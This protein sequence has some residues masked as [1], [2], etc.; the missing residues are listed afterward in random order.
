M[1][2]ATERGAALRRQ[3]GLQGQVD[4]EAVA[5]SLGLI[6]RR[7]PFAVLGE[8]RLGDYI[9]VANRL[10]P[11]WQRWVIAHA[12]GHRLLHP[13]NRLHVLLHPGNH[14][15]VHGLANLTDSFEHEADDFARALLVDDEEAIAERLTRSSEVAEYFGVPDELVRKGSERWGDS[16]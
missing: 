1:S 13:G 2:R 12:I 4:A 3:L 10:E 15:H 7:W 14:L 16:D 5:A 11:D 8:M 9:A 6:V